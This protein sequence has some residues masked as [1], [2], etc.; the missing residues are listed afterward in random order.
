MI[1]FTSARE[2]RLWSWALAVWVAIYATIPLAGSMVRLW[3]SEVILGVVFG[4]ALL[5]VIVAVVGIALQRRPSAVEVWVAV[6]V[7]AVYVALFV[8]MGVTPLE[9]T[10]LFEYGLLGVLIDRA[11][12]ERRTGGVRVPAPPVIAV[13]VT[14]LLG[15]G[16]EGLQA[17]LPDR[18][19]D[20]RD[21]GINA[22]AGLVAVVAFRSLFW[23]RNRAS[24][25]EGGD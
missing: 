11:L 23:A 13:I 8:R 19:Y 6:G 21:I 12:A 5:A 2:R 4:A 15:W 22:L 25:S 16:D 3:G 10:H 17:L 9:R 18:V 20:L 7:I 24:A 14:A 1:R